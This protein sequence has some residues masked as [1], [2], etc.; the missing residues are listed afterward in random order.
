QSGHVQKV[1]EILTDCDQDTLILKVTIDA[2]QCHTGYQSCF[3]RRLQ[4]NTNDQLE[5]IAQPTYNPKQV[6]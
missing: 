1:K 6:Y 3:Y 2:G 5:F 4:P